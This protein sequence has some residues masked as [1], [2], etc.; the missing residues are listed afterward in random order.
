[1]T[2]KEVKEKKKAE[3]NVARHKVKSGKVEQRRGRGNVGAGK[4][5]GREAQKKINLQK[6]G[7]IRKHGELE[8]QSI[9]LWEKVRCRN[10][11]IEERS[12]L[13]S[14]ILVK[15]N[16]KMCNM[17]TSHITSRVLQACLKHCRDAERDA[18]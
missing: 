3:G 5:S 16:G 7:R 18:I 2:K 6:P 1:M 15:M 13:L 4:G 14:E 8:R 11:E 10:L 9:H 12:R 17:G